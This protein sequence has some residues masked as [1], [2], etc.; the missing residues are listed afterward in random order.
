M[1]T[2]NL[3][4]VL[5]LLSI[6]VHLWAVG[7][8]N[9]EL[10]HWSKPL[11]MPLLAFYFWL[12][13]KTVDRSVRIGILAALVFSWLGDSLL[14]Y[15]SKAELYFLAGLGAFLVAQI[16]Y[17]FNFAQLKNPSKE[18]MEWRT[19]FSVGLLVIFYFFMLYTLWNFLG[20]LK[21][22]VILYGACLVGMLLMAVIRKNRTNETSFSLLFFGA[23]AFLVSDSMLAVS[24]FV[25]AFP[26]AGFW[27]MV[28]YIAA[29][30]LIVQGV[31]AHYDG[32][33]SPAKKS[34]P[35]GR[36]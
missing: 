15:Q 14:I 3:I 17:A 11:L 31:L 27:V 19:K 6:G 8:D 29:Q 28:S 18:K 23:I 22:P 36:R 7:V 2:R 34:V 24:K 35:K 16:M 32:V 5:F 26:M 9:A 12:S 30:A 20:N 25:G 10:I 21:V 13:S 33:P 4:S 1:N